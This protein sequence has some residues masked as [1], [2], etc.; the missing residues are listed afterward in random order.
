MN[1]YLCTWDTNYGLDYCIVSA[2]NAENADKLARKKASWDN[3]EVNLIT[4]SD[5][6]EVLNIPV[7]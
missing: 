1:L 5:K 4:P 7:L 2:L 3:I 6:E